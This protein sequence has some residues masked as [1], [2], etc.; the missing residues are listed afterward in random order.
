MSNKSCLILYSN[1]T[2]KKGQDSMTYSTELNLY[3]KMK[4]KDEE[5]GLYKSIVVLH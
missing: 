4:V 3:S 5:F 2:H 1:L